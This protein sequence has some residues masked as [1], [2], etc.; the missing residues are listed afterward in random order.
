MTLLI[1][2]KQRKV[3]GSNRNQSSMIYLVQE[4]ELEANDCL[5]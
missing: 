1:K 2:K 5:L 4:M 3:S